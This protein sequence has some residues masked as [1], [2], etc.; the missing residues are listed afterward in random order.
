MYSEHFWPDF[1]GGLIHLTVQLL[2][3]SDNACQPKGGKFMIQIEVP[4]L[5][6]CFSNDA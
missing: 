5:L 6:L 3:L 1:A 4:A 2:C